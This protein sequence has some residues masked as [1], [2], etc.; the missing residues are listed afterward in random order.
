M[1]FEQFKE[2]LTKDVKTH[3]VNL[4][5]SSPAEIYEVPHRVVKAVNC[6]YGAKMLSDTR[7]REKLNELN[8]RYPDMF[9]AAL[10]DSQCSYL[11]RLLKQST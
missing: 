11:T 5:A 7:N 6:E 2:N 10:N 9:K 8:R 3:E 1:D 4:L